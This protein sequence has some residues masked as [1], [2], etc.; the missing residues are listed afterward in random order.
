M[1]K[2]QYTRQSHQAGQP[3][4]STKPVV[5]SQTQWTRCGFLVI[6][7]MCLRPSQMDFRHLKLY[8]P[9]QDQTL[10]ASSN[11]HQNYTAHFW[12][13]QTLVERNVSSTSS[14]DHQNHTIHYWSAQALVERNV[15]S[16]FFNIEEQM[17]AANHSLLQPQNCQLSKQFR[18]YVYEDLPA[19]FT[20]DIERIIQ[21]HTTQGPMQ[22]NV[23]TEYA[24]LYL[25]RSSPCRTYNA[26]SASLFVVPYLH[27]ADC[28]F[29]PGYGMG[30]PQ[31]S[32]EKMQELFQHLQ[33]YNQQPRPPHLFM[34][35]YQREMSRG[36]I[37]N[38]PLWL[39][40]GPQKSVDARGEIVVPI[41][42]EDPRYQP[43]LLEA[44]NLYPQQ[45]QSEQHRR[46]AF[47]AVYTVALNP[48]MGRRQGKR[49]RK[50]LYD[51]V[52]YHYVNQTMAGLSFFVRDSFASFNSIVEQVYRDSILCPILPGDTV[53]MRR[54][55]DVI[56]NG[57]LPVLHEWPTKDNPNQTNWYKYNIQYSKEQ[58]YP[59][60]YEKED[61]SGIPY[62]SFV[63]TATG[64]TA[65]ETDFSPM[66]N[67]MEAILKEPQELH[68]RQRNMAKYAKRFTYGLGMDAYAYDDAFSQILL[69]LQRYVESLKHAS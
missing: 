62:D 41:F 7:I 9:H 50:Y 67:T 53:W 10:T 55:F 35:V 45:Q 13:A 19:Q 40:T 52:N 60:F 34:N 54:F 68:R 8:K 43:S 31:V 63:V 65:D 25:F 37:A 69:E 48:R 32:Q 24:L 61:Q 46:Y 39:T 3:T 17:A 15:S 27:Y 29:S 26:S 14:N 6:L 42:H 51:Y 47:A 64:N 56:R 20:T 30:C 66:F 11:D 59:F 28:Y 33:W 2:H 21:N 38:E 18:F 44:S 23:A 49:F 12:S 4:V 36:E 5:I 22:E 1:V 58:T 16:I 57:C